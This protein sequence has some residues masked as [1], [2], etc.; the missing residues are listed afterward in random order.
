MATAKSEK[1][2]LQRNSKKRGKGKGKREKEKERD[3][4]ANHDG[5]R[6]QKAQQKTKPHITRARGKISGG[7]TE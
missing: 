6:P 7:A 3:A 1:Q 5:V 4:T 2:T